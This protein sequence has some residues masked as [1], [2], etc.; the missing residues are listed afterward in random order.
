MPEVDSQLLASITDTAAYRA[1]ALAMLKAA[2][3][4]M[5]SLA[6]P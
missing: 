1:D 3:R 2:Q 4:E 5:L 6:K